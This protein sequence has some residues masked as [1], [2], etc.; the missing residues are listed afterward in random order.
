MR[1]GED[2]VSRVHTVRHLHHAH[3]F[4]SVALPLHHG[5]H[6]AVVESLLGLAGSGG[7]RDTHDAPAATASEEEVVIAFG[8]STRPLSLSRHDVPQPDVHDTAESLMMLGQQSACVVASTSGPQTSGVSWHCSLLGPQ[9][10]AQQTVGSPSGGA[11][12]IPVQSEAASA[13]GRSSAQAARRSG[14]CIAP[15][16]GH[17]VRELLN[18]Q[19]GARYSTSTTERDTWAHTAHHARRAHRNHRNHRRRAE[20]HTAAG[21]GRYKIDL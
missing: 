14:A 13:E 20:E 8:A 17:P 1:A 21:A 15:D 4:V 5:E 11:P 16:G 6:M 10:L 7:S 18:F 19:N 9:P 12:T 3:V 2:L